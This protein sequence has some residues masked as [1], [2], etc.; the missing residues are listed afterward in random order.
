MP[1]GAVALPAADPGIPALRDALRADRMLPTLARVAGLDGAAGEDAVLAAEVLSHKV[2][3]RCTIRYVLIS[4]RLAAGSR[5]IIAKVYRRPVLATRIHA[6]TMGLRTAALNGTEAAS[7]PAP[8]G[9]VPELGMALQEQLDGEDLRHPLAA[10]VAD[11]VLA[12]SARWL[13]ALHRARPI[14]DL[15]HKS[16]NHELD[17]ID[18]A[19]AEI[20]PHL[21][22]H[23]RVR[24]ERLRRRLHAL[25]APE[26]G[27]PSTMIHRDY[28]YAHVLC[29]AGR[30]GV[31]DFD[32]LSVGDPTLDVGH[33]LGHLQALGYRRVGDPDRFAEASSRFLQ[34][35]L[36]AAPA[37]V[38]AGL[39]F[40]KSYTHLKL[41]AT[42]VGQQRGEWRV[43]VARF[44]DLAVRSTEVP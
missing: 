35:Y 9:V 29:S 7:V 42:E 19:C 41:A 23:E 16:R 37:D 15:R 12:L 20:A 10:G 8:F 43:R 17:K 33:F 5:T 31:I 18:R 30:I 6:Y 3:Q 2:G 21:S 38:R 32:S 39:P 34:C 40:F 28:Y 36:D 25:G 22:S 24:I 27:A 44:A 1:S 11:D 4:E 26:D 14:P 13:A